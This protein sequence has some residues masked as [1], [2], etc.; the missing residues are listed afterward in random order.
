MNHPKSDSDFYRSSRSVSPEKVAMAFKRITK[1]AIDVNSQTACMAGS[2]SR[3]NFP[4]LQQDELHSDKTSHHIYSRT[5]E[6]HYILA[7][8]D[9]AN[10]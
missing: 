1:K 4:C 9:S 7:V 8:C 6:L 10:R 2:I 5:L 3:T